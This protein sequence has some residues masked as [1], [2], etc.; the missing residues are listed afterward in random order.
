[1][2]IKKFKHNLILISPSGETFRHH[3]GYIYTQYIP[4]QISYINE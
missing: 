2:K 1:M 3:I 4:L